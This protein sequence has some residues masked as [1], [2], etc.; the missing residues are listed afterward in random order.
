MTNRDGQSIAPRSI[1]PPERSVLLICARPFLNN[2]DRANLGPRLDSSLNWETLFSTAR[3]H[4]LLPLMY[5]HLSQLGLDRIPP[6]TAQNLKLSYQENVARN[7][8]LL[9]ELLAISVELK[10]RGIESLPFKGPVLGLFAYGDPGLRQSADIDLVVQLKDVGRASQCLT[11]HGYRLTRS[12]DA[13]QVKFLVARQHNIQFAQ[14]QGRVMIELHWRIAPKLFAK[15]LGAD[16]LWSKL[17]TTTIK[18]VELS[19]LPV[20]PLLL[21]LCV[22]GARHLWER[23]SWVTDLAAVISSARSIDWTEVWALARRTQTQRM[24]LVGLQLAHELLQAPLPTEMAMAISDDAITTKVADTLATK[25]FQIQPQSSFRHTFRSNLR[26]RN[27]WSSRL[28]YCGFAISPTDGELELMSVPRGF[29]FVYYGLR[30]WRLL[31]T[32]K[33][34]HARMSS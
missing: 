5:H 1:G 9:D 4:G 31:S 20:E 15:G 32:R 19:S 6:A 33:S 2:S 16:D 14:D 11:E 27:G 8:V 12:L 22:H 17:E 7:I 23:L 18:K 26:M 13:R 21:A 25:L 24:L 34:R 3:R 10:S 29:N 30:P 28:R